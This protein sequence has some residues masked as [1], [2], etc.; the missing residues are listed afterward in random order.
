MKRRIT[1]YI[2]ISALITL[3]L[4]GTFTVILLYNH[5]KG[6]VQNDV[7]A[8][9]QLLKSAQET[10]RDNASRT[11]ATDDPTLLPEWWS[12][13]M[14]TF[15]H[16]TARSNEL[17]RLTVIRPS[18]E[19]LYESLTDPKEMEFHADRPE[20]IAAQLS[21]NGE[22][23]RG[24]DTIR[25]DFY[26]YALKLNNDLVMRVSRSMDSIWTSFS[27]ALPAL[28]S[29]LL[30]IAVLLPIWASWLTR[31]LLKPL[32]TLDLNAPLDN[33]TYPELSPLLL[34]IDRQQHLIGAASQELKRREHEFT[35]LIDNMQEGLVLLDATDSI[36]VANPGAVTL[37]E[38]GYSRSELIGKHFSVLMRHPDFLHLPHTLRSRG[39]NVNQNISLD[40]R[41]YTVSA[42]AIYN[43]RNEYTG[44]ILLIR[45]TTEQAE[46]ERFRREFTAN[47]S[48]ELKTPLTTITGYA[49]LLSNNMVQYADVSSI[50]ATIATEAAS[51]LRLIDD[52]MQLSRLDENKMPT[53]FRVME[54]GNIIAK[55]V[56]ALTPQAVAA[57]VSLTADISEDCPVRADDHLLQQLIMNLIDNGIRYNRPGGEVRLC[58]WTDERNL[59]HISVADTGIGIPPADLPRIF[60]RFYRVDK[61]HDR[62]TGGTGLGLSIVKHLTSLFGAEIRVQSEPDVGSIFTI[63]F[64]HC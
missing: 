62:K 37:Q 6:S 9:G 27:T 22:A 1:A 19:V 44:A 3:L 32:D 49:D 35:V 16:Q 17:Y 52:I 39:V 43:S 11:E 61:S 23:T 41:I 24:S 33:R 63:V 18:G 20:F 58:C 15:S 57:E 8:F 55:S 31:R 60:E 4:T 12:D 59:T 56:A 10:A 5:H 26:Y 40:N 47:V 50:G 30:A 46:T 28:I 42:T 48:H 45:D 54:A 25:K 53:D 29:I 38:P 34:N 64:P 13:I 2:I 14:E 51:L 7:R 36:V 21:G